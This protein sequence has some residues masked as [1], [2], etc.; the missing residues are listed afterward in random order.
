MATRKGSTMSTKRHAIVLLL[1]L[2]WMVPG[3]AFAARK[4][5]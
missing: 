4:A 3:L 1:V 2:I 5:E